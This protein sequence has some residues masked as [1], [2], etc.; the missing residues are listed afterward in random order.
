MKNK[1][2]MAY[3]DDSALQKDLYYLGK[4]TRNNARITVQAVKKENTKQIQSTTLRMMKELND[5]IAAKEKDGSRYYILFDDGD[6]QWTAAERITTDD[7]KVGSKVFTNWKKKG[8]YY[9]GRVTQ[10]KGDRIHIRYDDGD[11]ETTTIS[12]VRILR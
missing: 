7:I 9:S 12:V 11:K 3:H 4:Q 8:R 1:N 5:K 2:G 6:K 10:R